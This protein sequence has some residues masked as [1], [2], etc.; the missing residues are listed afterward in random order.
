[1][2][3]ERI[4]RIPANN[5]R[6]IL[7]SLS[8]FVVVQLARHRK[9]PVPVCSTKEIPAYRH[10]H[11]WL[12]TG[13]SEDGYHAGSTTTGLVE[14]YGSDSIKE[15]GKNWRTTTSAHMGRQSSEFSL[16]YLKK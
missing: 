4:D 2:T 3:M 7:I 12:L 1:M 6:S 11:K 10:G 8:I 5:I 13:T 16:E 15:E 14:Q 9:T